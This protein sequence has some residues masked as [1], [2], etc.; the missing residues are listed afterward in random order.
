MKNIEDKSVT[1]TPFSDIPVRYLNKNIIYENYENG[2]YIGKDTIE[3]ILYSG[4]ILFS[5]ILSLIFMLWLNGKF[6]K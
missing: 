4:V 5:I 3:N 2:I 1:P 6:T